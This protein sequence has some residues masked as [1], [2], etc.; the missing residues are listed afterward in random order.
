MDDGGSATTRIGKGASASGG[1]AT[2]C[3]GKGEIVLDTSLGLTDGDSGYRGCGHSSGSWSMDKPM[4][5]IET[6]TGG[7]EVIVWGGRVVGMGIGKVV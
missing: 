7:R 5:R 3:V 1:A 4:V 6:C 2:I